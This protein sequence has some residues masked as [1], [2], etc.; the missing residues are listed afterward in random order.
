MVRLFFFKAFAHF[1]KSLS[2]CEDIMT[3]YADSIDL[4]TH[5]KVPGAMLCTI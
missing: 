1:L 4:H 2:H 5:C 3:I